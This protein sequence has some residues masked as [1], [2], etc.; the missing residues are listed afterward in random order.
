MSE[1]IKLFKLSGEEN[2]AT[3]RFQLEV[4]LKAEDKYQ[5]IK[6]GK[7]KGDDKEKLEDWTKVDN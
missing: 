2:Y 3:W 7:P 5:K 1:E 4:V 6:D